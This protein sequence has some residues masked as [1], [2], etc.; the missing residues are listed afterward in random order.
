MDRYLQYRKDIITCC[1]WLMP[2]RL[3]SDPCS[4]P[5]AMSPCGFPDEPA[6]VI[7]PSGR[8]YMELVPADICVMDFDLKPD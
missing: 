1:Q 5:A 7:T 4:A 8:P 3:F 6:L 2:A